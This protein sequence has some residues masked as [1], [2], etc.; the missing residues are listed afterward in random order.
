MSLNSFL[1]DRGIAITHFSGY[2]SKGN[3]QC[4]RYNGVIW[5][6]IKL[7]LRNRN[8]PLSRWEIVVTDV[9]HSQR[10][11]LCTVTNETP[12]ERF[13]KFSRRSKSGVSVPTWLM[14]EPNTVF[15]K[16]HVRNKYDP[17]VDKVEVVQL[18]P[19]HGV[20]RYPNGHNSTVSIRDLA[21]MDNALGTFF[22]VLL[23]F[24]S[25]HSKKIQ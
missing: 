6:S 14:Q 17:L 10:S 13:L 18:N 23:L 4:E 22:F 1:Y 9:L 19:N 8:L 25:C 3:A 12:H 21:P 2:N 20:V 5:N 7:A 15:A 16:H 11:L 24:R